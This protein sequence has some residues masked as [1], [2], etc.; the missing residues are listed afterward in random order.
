MNKMFTAKAHKYNSSTSLLTKLPN[1]E[2]LSMHLRQSD[3]RYLHACNGDEYR[4]KYLY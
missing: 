4:S 1:L 3:R 2:D